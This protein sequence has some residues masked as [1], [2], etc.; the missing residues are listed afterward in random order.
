MP[1]VDGRDYCV[2][3]FQQITPF[4]NEQAHPDYDQE[5]AS[6][7]TCGMPLIEEDNGTDG[8]WDVCDD[9]AGA[10]MDDLLTEEGW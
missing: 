6:C 5:A 3:C 2:K 7:Y 4:I 10:I 1:R 9:L 8:D